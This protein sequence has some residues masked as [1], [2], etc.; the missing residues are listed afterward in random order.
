MKKMILFT[1]LAILSLSSCNNESRKET[2]QGT[3]SFELST[4][5][6]TYDTINRIDNGLKQGVWIPHTNADTLVYLN[7]TSHSVTP[8]ITS[9]EIMRHLKKGGNKKLLALANGIDLS[10]YQGDEVDYLNKKSDQ[11]SFVICKATEG[12]KYTDPDFKNNWDMIKNKG[13]TR[14]AYHFYHCADSPEKQAQFFLTVIGN[15]TTADFPPIVDFEENSIDKSCKKSDIQKNLLIFLQLLKKETGR[16][17]IIY[18]DLNTGNAYLNDE[19]LSSYPLWIANYNGEASPT[20]PSVWKNKRWTLWQKTS[21]YK[22]GDNV[23]DFDIYNG[24]LIEF[25]TFIANQ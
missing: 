25:R 21:S 14:G 5:T 4:N 10:H 20:Q 22:L 8:A 9:G 15:I 1:V 3:N 18:T 6:N 23:N 12:L 13:F 11:L 16:Q 7:D 17:P 24:N 19:T 2:K